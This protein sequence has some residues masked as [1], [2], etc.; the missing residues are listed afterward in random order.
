V[1]TYA[2]RYNIAP[3]QD[4]VAI[5]QEEAG[6]IASMM[7]WGLIPH[8]AKDRNM[9]A[10]MINAR[11]ETVAE[12]PS[13]RVPFKR[14]RGLI[15][16]DGFYEWKATGGKYKQ[17]Y[18]ITL[19]GEAP[20]AMA[21]LWSVWSDPAIE[22]PEKSRVSSC[23]IITTSANSVMEELHA[24]MPVILPGESWSVWLDPELPEDRPSTA[25]L[26]SLLTSYPAENMQFRAVSR[27]VSN[28]RNE[29]PACLN[30][31]D[32]EG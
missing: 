3:T 13:F 27:L 20:F 24:R 5:R 23:T 19:D 15:P 16:A 9:A 8:W 11:G 1:E 25:F 31:P 7:H 22:D 28:A 12:K 30:Q 18:H 14:Q 17:P 29:T 32:P 4:I 2:P 6:R 26:E 21:G 10:R